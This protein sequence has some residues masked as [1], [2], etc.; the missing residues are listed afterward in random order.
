LSEPSWPSTAPDWQSTATP[1]EAVSAET[2]K[3]S[4]TRKGGERGARAREAERLGLHAG[5]PVCQLMLAG[6]S[7]LKPPDASHL[8]TAL[9]MSVGE[10]HT[11]DDKLIELSGLLDRPDGK[12]LKICKPS[13]TDPTPLFGP[14]VFGAKR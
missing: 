14:D 10:M 4:E 1:A 6:Y 12:K 8:A 2:D 13:T 7:K 5:A 11:F 9:L 3:I